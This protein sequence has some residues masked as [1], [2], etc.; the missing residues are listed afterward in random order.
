MQQ[1]SVSH[2]ICI[3]QVQTYRLRVH[4][5]THMRSCF[6]SAARGQYNKQMDAS[7]FDFL[8]IH[9]RCVHGNGGEAKSCQPTFSTE[10]VWLH[11]PPKKKQDEA[12]EPECSHV[13]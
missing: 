3:L 6:K 7:F 12:H 8:L 11:H 10:K 9:K 13:C 4:I 5:Q 1:G 2:R